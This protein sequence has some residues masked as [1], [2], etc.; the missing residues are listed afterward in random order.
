MGDVIA[1]AYH[2]FLGISSKMSVS[3]DDK[4]SSS[5]DLALDD[6]EAKGAGYSFLDSQIREI[7]D[8]ENKRVFLYNLLFAINDSGPF[9]EMALAKKGLLSSFYK[10]A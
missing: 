9:D 2:S 7:T 6:A 8:P 4:L 5:L 1:V 3:S 10:D